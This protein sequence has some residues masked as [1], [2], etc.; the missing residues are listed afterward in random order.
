MILDIGCG[1]SKLPGAIGIDRMKQP[2]VDV[3]HDLNRTPWPFADNTFDVIVCQDTIQILD[4]ILDTMNE[5]HRI[6]KP[7][8]VVK[9]RTPHYS[10]PNSWKDPL[11]KWHLA[12]DSFDYFLEDFGYPKYTD[13]TYH[14][15][16]K[17]FI[18]NRKLGIGNLLARLSPR[19][20]EKYY[21]HRYPPYNM[22]FELQT[23]K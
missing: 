4:S 9:I 22:Y 10:H 7:G 5:I 8:A 3:V 13:R 17:E 23:V 2:G 1:G 15:I 21:A 16:K 20:Y 18:F 12:F 11:H 14:M 6:A 19:R